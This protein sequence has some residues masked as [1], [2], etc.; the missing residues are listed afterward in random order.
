MKFQS[1]YPYT[2]QLLKEYPEVSAGE[3]QK[4]L[5]KSQEA[6]Q[7]WKKT[8]LKDRTALLKRIARQLLVNK[9]VYAALIHQEM[10]KLMEEAIAEVEKSALVCRYYAEQGADF[11]EEHSRVTVVGKGT[12]RYMPLGGI[13]TIMPWNF[14]FWQVFRFSAPALM[15]GNVLLLKHAPNVMG[16]AM[17]IE[18]LMKD[19]EMPEGVFQVLPINHEQVIHVIE[20]K[21]VQGVALTGSEKTG[22]IVASLAGQNIKKTVM[23]LGGS[24]AFI[25][26]ENADI[27]RAVQMAVKSR[28]NNAGQ[29]CTS[30]KR[31][32]LHQDIAQAFKDQLLLT[33]KNLP[34]KIEERPIACLAREDLAITLEKQMNQ[35]IEEGATL[36]YGGKREG[37]YFEPTVLEGVLPGMPAFDE[38]TF[39]PLFCLTIAKDEAHAI[40]LTN[41]SRYGLAASVWTKDIDRAERIS[42]DL[43]V[44]T[45]SINNLVKS[46][47]ELPFGGTKKSGYGRELAGYGLKEF[48]N[49]KTVFV[50]E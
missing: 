37:L 29:A 44:G 34:N 36:L 6:F 32:I 1:I 33:L 23:E 18:Q 17:A 5:A 7:Y 20:S 39:G 41:D 16:C 12:V 13:L 38:E 46:T 10:G 2:G 28:L 30:A 3:L 27:E 25:V 40:A 35:S 11:L 42:E 4:R 26:L 22:S 43:E 49:V 15:A 9:E 50:N 48:V 8:A 21:I 47:P 19:M 45:V 14:P 31:F 24:D